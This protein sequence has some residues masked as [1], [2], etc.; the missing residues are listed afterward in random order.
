VT[1]GFVEVGLVEL[2]SDMQ[3]RYVLKVEVLPLR[4]R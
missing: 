4:N 3:A 1:Q 2:T